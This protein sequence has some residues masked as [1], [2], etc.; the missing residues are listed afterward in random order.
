MGFYEGCPDLTLQAV[1]AIELYRA[2]TRIE[3]LFWVL[4]LISMVWTHG[5]LLLRKADIADF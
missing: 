5:M 3:T 2:R 4:A 1:D